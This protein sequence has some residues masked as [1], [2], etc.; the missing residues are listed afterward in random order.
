VGG[1]VQ[2]QL[3]PGFPT[4]ESETV[5]NRVTSL[6]S[7]WH[8]LPQHCKSLEQPHGRLFK[9]LAVLPV[10]EQVEGM[11]PVGVR[12]RSSAARPQVNAVEVGSS[13]RWFPPGDKRTPPDCWVSE[14][15]LHFARPTRGGTS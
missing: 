11:Y 15:R 10:V 8:F 1:L 5:T 12:R 6:G 13:L 3:I 4:L 9:A 14:Q 7:G 2:D